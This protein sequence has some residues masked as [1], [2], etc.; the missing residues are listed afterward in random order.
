M[1]TIYP[2]N[3]EETTYND[4]SPAVWEEVVYVCVT[5]PICWFAPA[6]LLGAPKSYARLPP[7]GWLAPASL[8][9]VPK[10]Y[11][12]THPLRSWLA[13]A[14][15]LGV[16]TKATRVVPVPRG[17]F[18]PASPMA[19]PRSRTATRIPVGLF[20]PASPMAV[21]SSQTIFWTIYAPDEGII[22]TSHPFT[23]R[24][25][26]TM[27]ERATVRDLTTVSSRVQ[28]AIAEGAT[29]RDLTALLQE[30]VVSEAVVA[31]DSLLGTL[32]VL[33]EFAEGLVASEAVSGR[34]HALQVVSEMVVAATETRA[35]ALVTLLESLEVTGG[36]E[37]DRVKVLLS[38][39]ESVEVDDLT[40]NQLRLTLNLRE[41]VAVDDSL[42]FT[43]QL[44]LAI[45]E[46]V[47]VNDGGV[48]ASGG[49][50]IGDR[51]YQ[52]WV[53]N[54]E[55]LGSWH[56]DNYLFTGFTECQGRFFGVM[57]DGV[58]TLE[59]DTDAGASIEAVVAT[60]LSELGSNHL[61]KMTRAYLHV[62]HKGEMML[63]V[64]T[65]NRGVAEEN[66]YHVDADPAFE[67]APATKRVR[68][69]RGTRST[70]WGLTLSNLDGADFD[71]RG[72]DVYAVKLRRKI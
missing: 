16:P 32:R 20:A 1:A 43:A 37:L 47:Q 25:F 24:P 41:G 51:V 69:Q 68:L 15:L 70:L 4:C 29:V 31:E 67:S 49:M 22:V 58:Y 6:S 9:G 71:V 10:S 45:E 23:L 64:R 57:M 3:W 38:I 28:V 17:F 34:V 56:Y 14:S 12:L 13:P 61:K 7:V 48:V 35:A 54:T 26:T 46:S 62:S 19:V 33:L 63:R 59:G 53:M 2:P 8:L 21:P 50:T 39:L 60:G 44:A 65:S 55:T 18:A 52:A 40:P 72:W 11:T 66:W 42:S 36:A 27:R 5:Y 30:V